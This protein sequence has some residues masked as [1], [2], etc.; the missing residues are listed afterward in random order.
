MKIFVLETVGRALK[1]WR[2]TS[3]GGRW[4]LMLRVGVRQGCW[5]RSSTHISVVLD[6]VDIKNALE[7]GDYVCRRSSA[8]NTEAIAGKIH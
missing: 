6:V 4:L 1:I 2:I 7:K 5:I 3:R 8:E